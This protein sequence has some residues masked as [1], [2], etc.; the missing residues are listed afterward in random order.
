MGRDSLIDVRFTREQWGLCDGT[1]AFTS[2][3]G[4]TERCDK[5][6]LYVQ[7]REDEDGNHPRYC[8]GHARV[9]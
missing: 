1:I 3:P 8:A 5:P 4:V 7:K 6:A 9:A 2:R